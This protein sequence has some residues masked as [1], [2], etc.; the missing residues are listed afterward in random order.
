MSVVSSIERPSHILRGAVKA[1]MV[2]VCLVVLEQAIIA[3]PA[4]WRSAGPSHLI[5]GPSYNDPCSGGLPL[6]C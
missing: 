6:P 3:A 5:P 4:H 2:V 1:L